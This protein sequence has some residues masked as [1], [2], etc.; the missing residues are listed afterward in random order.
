MEVIVFIII[1]II[2]FI[3]C[4]GLNIISIYGITGGNVTLPCEHGRN[5]PHHIVWNNENGSTLVN[6]LQNRS[7]SGNEKIL[8]HSVLEL[9][10][11]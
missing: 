9:K 3:R 6:K 2:P 4:E 5:N 7:I 10:Q 1:F 8:K 11:T